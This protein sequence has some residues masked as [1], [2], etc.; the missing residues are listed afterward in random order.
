MTLP[1]PRAETVLR[2]WERGR[3]EHPIDRA[4]TML[5]LFNKWSR[6]EVAA[7]SVER[8]DAQLLAWRTKLFGPELP[9]YASCSECGCGVDVAL[10]VDADDDTEEQFTVDVGG[11]AVTVRLPTSLDLAA[12]AGCRSVDEASRA[13]IARC[14]EDDARALD[15][16]LAALVEAEWDHRA[17]LSA[18][19]VALACPDCDHHWVLDLDV[20]EFLWREIEIEAERLLHEVDLLARRYGWSERDILALSTTRR[21]LYLGLAS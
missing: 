12:V 4:V 16:E 17:R 3:R 8:R 2:I 11:Q 1:G 20:A 18:G 15:E 9:G 14:V 19:A 7:V 5:S 21:K 10:T 13:L 6:D